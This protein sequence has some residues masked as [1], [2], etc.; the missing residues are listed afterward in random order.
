MK[1][2]RVL[3]CSGCE[4]PLQTKP[5]GGTYCSNCHCTPSMQDTFIIMKCPMDDSQLN[6]FGDN[7]WQ[8]PQCNTVYD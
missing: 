5:G 7:Q 8:C 4:E 6:R 1:A 3:Y 2:T